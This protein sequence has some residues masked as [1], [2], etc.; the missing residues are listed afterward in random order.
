M[1]IIPIVLLLSGVSLTACSQNAYKPPQKS[2]ETATISARS[3]N[4]FQGSVANL[5]GTGNVSILEINGKEAGGFLKTNGHAW[6]LKAGENHLFVK[7]TPNASLMSDD[8]VGAYAHLSFEAQAGGEY[9]IS[10]QPELKH[11]VFKITEKKSQ[12]SL[13]QKRVAK[14]MLKTGVVSPFDI[15]STAAGG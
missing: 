4:G 5:A 1:K 9:V 2:S 3:L 7:G 10:S 13:V 11:I 15:L 6:R 8:S 14:T 12:A